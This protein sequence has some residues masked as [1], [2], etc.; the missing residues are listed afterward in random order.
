MRSTGR[1]EAQIVIKDIDGLIGPAPLAGPIPQGVLQAQTF[2]RA[3]HLMR[4]RLPQVNDGLAGQM[5]G[6]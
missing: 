4:C 6:G 5:L 1:G 2:L 3:S